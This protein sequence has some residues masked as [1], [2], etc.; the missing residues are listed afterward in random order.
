MS[1]SIWTRERKLKALEDGIL[2]SMRSN[3]DTLTN[4]LLNDDWEE[5]SHSANAIMVE[6]IRMQA[7]EPELEGVTALI[8][9]MQ[10]IE[11]RM[12]ALEKAHEL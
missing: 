9:G 7:I 1:E 10:R 4:E 8:D 11:E 5:A 3:L 12:D 2:K 6:C